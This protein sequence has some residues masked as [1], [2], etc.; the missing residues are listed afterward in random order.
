MMTTTRVPEYSFSE[1]SVKRPRIA[2]QA[3]YWKVP[4]LEMQ[5]TISDL[6]EHI[7]QLHYDGESGNI[8]PGC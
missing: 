5:G 8:E 3:L 2:H 7:M 4:V 1:Q 6:R